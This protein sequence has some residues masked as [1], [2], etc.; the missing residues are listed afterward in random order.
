MS[1]PRLA[2]L[3]D[4]LDLLDQ[5][6]SLMNGD[7]AIVAWNKTLLRMLEFPERL[8][9]VGAPLEVFIRYNAERGEY[10]PGDVE[11]LVAA[12]V[13][14][15]RTFKPHH[16]ERTR[17]NG[18]IIS[19]RGEPLPNGGFV[20]LYTDVTEQRRAEATIQRQNAELEQRVRERTFELE[21]AN[22]RLRASNAINIEIADALRRSEGRLRLITDAIPAFIAYVDADLVYRF[23]NRGYAAWFSRTKDTIVGRSVADV[24]GPE[25]CSVLEPRVR[26]AL[27]GQVE[28]YE[29]ELT[30]AD[31]TVAYAR[32]TLV[33][34]FDPEGRVLGVFVLSSDITAE[35]QAQATLLYATRMETVGQLAGGLAHDFNNLLTVLLG[36]LGGLRDRLSDRPDLN[37]LIDP[38]LLAARRGASAVKRLLTLASPSADVRVT[39]IAG[40]LSEITPLLRQSLP[41][42]ILLEV[43]VPPQ[44]LLVTVDPHGLESAI[45]N[46][47]LN[48]RD[49]MP[50][51]GHLA[52]AAEA[53]M[54]ANGAAPCVGIRVSDTGVGMDDAVRA[55]AFEPFFTTK[56]RG[57]G[58]GLGLAMVRAF[59]DQSGGTI[60]IDSAPGAGT[61]IEL[62]LPWIVEGAD[63]GIGR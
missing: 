42:T 58:G 51:G 38:S 27:K 23:A 16:F 14:A 34:E 15:A 25:L 13:A 54:S 4:G 1:D 30:R 37:A 57:A 43:A 28:S 26:R 52:I 61:R 50:E 48:S 29:Y 21:E 22:A 6:F 59:V 40:L 60:R 3:Q 44:P 31:G 35:K 12:R 56:P 17:P 32:S 8:A 47:A 7:L 39:D 46:L 49:A 55:R 10:G 53:R 45:L 20:T 33:P 36:N 9:R 63:V 11:R 18:R 62:L 19:I 5:G 24:V 2:Q 41:A